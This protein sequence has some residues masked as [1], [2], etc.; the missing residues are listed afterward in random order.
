MARVF[1]ENITKKFGTVTAVNNVSLEIPDRQ[2]TVLVGPSGCGKTTALRLV[3]GLEEA[4]AG[5]IYIGDRVVNDVAPKDRDIAMVFQNYALYPHM[6]VYD[7]MAFGLRLRRYARPEIDRRVKEAAGLLGIEQLLGR[8]PKQLSGGQRQRVALG[9][10]IVREPQV[11][12]MDEPLSNLD[13]KLRVQTRAE[14][15]KLQA[16]LQT[17]T[18]YVTHDQVEAMTMGDRIVVMRDGLVQ[19]VDSPLNL[20]EK[21]ANLFVAGFI[22]SPAMNFIE[23]TIARRDGQTVVDADSFKMDIPADIAAYAK[24]WAGRKVIFGIRPEDIQDRA[25][26]RDIN[27]AWGLRAMVDV[28]EPLGSDVILYL[29]TGPHSIVAR[30]DAHSDAKMGQQAEV[31]FNM[32]KMHLFDPQTHQVII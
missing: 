9:R 27:P 6:S 8:K 3:A 30:V 26:A 22:G 11:F 12:L 5:N 19:Q 28:H 25:F 13:A 31:V 23:A 7:N 4:T 29:S 32:R 16:R 10:A 14:I 24:D 21:P 20:Y 18:I 17:T 2:F 1:L 15:K